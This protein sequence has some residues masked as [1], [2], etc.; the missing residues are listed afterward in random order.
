MFKFLLSVVLTACVAIPAAAQTPGF[1]ESSEKDTD[2]GQLSLPLGLRESKFRAGNTGFELYV[3]AGVDAKALVRQVEATDDANTIHEKVDAARKRLY[4]RDEIVLS[5]GPGSAS[6]R[7]RPAADA[8]GASLVRAIYWWNNRNSSGVY[9]YAQYYA[10]AATLFVDDVSGRYYIY[11]RYASGGWVK[12]ST[13]SSGG[14][15]TRATY[16]SYNFRGFRGT[17]SGSSRADIVMY[18]FR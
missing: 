1:G 4:P 6:G 12:R 10:A 9:W 13:V 17:A 11:D 14:A 16:G 2:E 3:R 7:E 8:P 5:I 15:F 18:F